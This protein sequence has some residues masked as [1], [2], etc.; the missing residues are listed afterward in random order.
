MKT[1]LLIDIGNSALKWAL[2]DATGRSPF[3]VVEHRN[4]DIAVVLNSSFAAIEPPR[5]CVICS[6]ADAGVNVRMT[7]WMEGVW[8]ITPYFVESSASLLGLTNGYLVPQQLGN[9]RWLA[10]IAA[11]HRQQGAV[12]VVDC[13]TAVTIDLVDAAG[14]HKGGWIL[15]G[16]RLFAQCLRANTA[17][18]E[19]PDSVGTVEPGADTAAAIANGAL[20]SVIGAVERI[21]REPSCSGMKWIVTG[22]D[23][24]VIAGNLSIDNERVDELLMDGLELIANR[25]LDKR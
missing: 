21:A 14:T 4:F 8:A 25:L 18:P 10:V 16:F 23:A 9:D 13:G 1:I 3:E 15:P 20:M 12:G 11:Y 19:F 6:V 24:A 2:L 5:L 7:Q 22:G 17:I